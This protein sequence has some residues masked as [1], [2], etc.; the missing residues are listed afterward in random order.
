MQENVQPIGQIA[1]QV[2]DAVG[3]PV[4]TRQLQR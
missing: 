2:A 3:Q 4:S 1:Q